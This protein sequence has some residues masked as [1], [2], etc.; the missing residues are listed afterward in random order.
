MNGLSALIVVAV[1]LGTV[2]LGTGIAGQELLFGVVIPYA[3]IA[4]FL[5]GL[6]Y[7]ILCWA[8]APVP[9]KITTSCGQHQSLPW[10]KANK[11]ESPPD[12]KW[13]VGRMA[14]E[15]LFFRS[16]FRN[17]KA[18]L[19]PGQRLIHQSDRLLWLGALAFHW[20]FLIIFLR[21]LRFFLEPVPVFVQGLERVD[22]LFQVAVP[23]LFL[24][25]VV[26]VAALLYLLGRRFFNPLVRYISL[27]SDYLALY[28]VL[29]VALSGI[30]MRYFTRVDLLAVKQ[31]A[32]GLVTL[33]P[34]V[35]EGIGLAFYVHV[36]F[37]SVLF[38]YFPFSKL[39][40]MGGVFLSPT[41]NMP[42]DNR[43]RRHVNPINPE[44]E[45]HTYAQW[46]EEFKDKLEGA[47]IPLDRG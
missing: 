33:R 32:L 14:L 39:M 13:T 35:P 24:T 15:I 25:D 34:A 12:A 2:W 16:L 8:R 38:A 7:R 47:G 42:N 26:I 44:V 31:L 43:K 28:L 19:A 5:L 22:E 29:A 40:H 23:T 45:V 21:H 4:V 11:L 10:I 37:V 46:E 41:R 27:A 36:F 18:E 20:S 17:T 3:A 30:L 9:F 1:L 6:V